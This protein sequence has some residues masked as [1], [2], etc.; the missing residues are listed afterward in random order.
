MKANKFFT[1]LKRHKTFN[2]LTINLVYNVYTTYKAIYL[3]YSDSIY[4]YV[5]IFL[6]TI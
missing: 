2:K 1:I 3:I 5:Y 4:K 6:I